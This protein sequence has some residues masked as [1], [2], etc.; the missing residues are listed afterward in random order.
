MKNQKARI[1]KKE[2]KKEEEQ[3]QINERIESERTENK[4]NCYTE[5]KE[6]SRFIIVNEKQNRKH[7]MNI[8]MRRKKW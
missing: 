4:S 1:E 7:N 5:T 2:E 6:S 8:E 3:D